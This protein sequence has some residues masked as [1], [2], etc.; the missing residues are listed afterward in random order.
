MTVTDARPA[1]VRAFAAVSLL[2]ALLGALLLSGP[3]SPAHADDSG[4]IA[5]RLNEARAGSG[6]GPLTRNGGLDAVAV[7][8]AAQMAASGSLS[9]NPAVGGQI[10]GGWSRWGENVAQGQSSGSA[11]HDGWWGSAGHQ[12]NMLGAFTD[13]GI[14][15]LRAGG[16]TWGV[17]VFANYGGGGGGA[18]AS[19]ATRNAAAAETARVAE[20]S[21]VAEVARVAEEARVAEAARV[22]EVERVRAEEVATAQAAEVV[23]VDL[24]RQAMAEQAATLVVAQEQADR[25]S[26]EEARAAAEKREPALEVAA[27]SAWS[28]IGPGGN[29]AGAAL[30]VLASA[31]V[32][33][34]LAMLVPGIRN[35]VIAVVRGRGTAKVIQVTKR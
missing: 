35:R 5:A 4:V 9:H 11:M 10:P 18:Q 22:V 26:A 16:T 24:T 7:Q 34:G 33:G 3:A 29:G 21:R 2:V 23:R 14:A 27:A 25:A 31:F 28:D 12:A 13:V 15:F 8:W 17:Q 6:L 19:P 30:V 1:P 20:A 32:L